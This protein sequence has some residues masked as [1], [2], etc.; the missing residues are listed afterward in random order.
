MSSSDEEE[1]DAGEAEV[2]EQGLEVVRRPAGEGPANCGLPALQRTER[3]A[4]LCPLPHHAPA[5]TPPPA[6]GAQPE[7]VTKYKTAADIANR[8]WGPAAGRP[9]VELCP[10]PRQL[11]PPRLNERMNC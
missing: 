9:A 10:L 8:E 6:R 4:A 1:V 11:S 2:V 5:V 7:V 3:A